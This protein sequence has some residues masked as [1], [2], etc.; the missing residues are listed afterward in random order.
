MYIKYTT[1]IQHV[2]ISALQHDKV[3][4]SLTHFSDSYNV[5]MLMF[6][7]QNIGQLFLFVCLLFFPQMMKVAVIWT[8]TLVICLFVDY[9]YGQK[10]KLI[11][12]HLF[13]WFSVTHIL[14]GNIC[15]V[16][17]LQL[18]IHWGPQSMMYLK[19]KREFNH[20]TDSFS[21]Y[22]RDVKLILVS[23]I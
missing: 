6:R 7:I 3:I 13:H 17:P 4:W 11:A 18:N 22:I 8:C 5:G 10:V 2:P 12:T 16:F 19:G 15:C 9:C 14:P 20:N 23:L 1:Y 21:L